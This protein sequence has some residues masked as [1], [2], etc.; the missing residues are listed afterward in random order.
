MLRFIRLFISLLVATFSFCAVAQESYPPP[1]KEMGPDPTLNPKKKRRTPK[2]DRRYQ[3]PKRPPIRAPGPTIAPSNMSPTEKYEFCFEKMI[4]GGETNNK[5]MRRCLGIAVRS[6]RPGKKTK[7][8]LEFLDKQAVNQTFSKSMAIFQKCY[9]DHSFASKKKG[10]ILEGYL[11]PTLAVK[12]DGS[13]TKIKFSKR[14]IS[15][16]KL[17]G[18]FKAELYKMTFPVFTRRKNLTVI[19]GF[20]LTSSNKPKIQKLKDMPRIKGA[21]AYTNEE[22]LE[23]Y[24]IGTPLITACYDALLKIQPTA[25][26][27]TG[28]KLKVAPSGK[29]LNVTLVEN[30]L[31]EPTF[32]EC[33]RTAI[34]SYKFP[35]SRSNTAATIHYPYIFALDAKSVK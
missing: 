27:R 19:N 17:L 30:S 35:K 24:R 3:P 11:E 25:A 22:K 34:F 1:P 23:V 21:P 9:S 20:K 4:D 13:V 8:T 5:F 26:G 14:T 6:K 16:P 10:R 28:A 7:G 15:D 33:L 12:K 2:K 29:V 32:V 31:Y 18:C